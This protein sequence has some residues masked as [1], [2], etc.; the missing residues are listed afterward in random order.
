MFDISFVYWNPLF[1]TRRSLWP[2]FARLKLVNN[3]S[4]CFM[5]DF[6]EML[7]STEKFG[8]TNVE[9]IRMNLFREFLDS[10]GLM[11]LSLQGCKFTWISN[12]SN[13]FVTR[14]KIDNV[15][16]NWFGRN[17][18]PHA[19]FLALPII[20]SDHSPIILNPNPPIASGKS[21]KYESFGEE[22]DDYRRE[23]STGWI[24]SSHTDS[25]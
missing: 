24:S 5:G 6:N 18:L 2:I 13:V 3:G 25:W 1:S 11:D 15:L 4:W 17:R 7:Y 20:N 14:Q 19:L 23:L 12:P 10:P 22:H 9:P 21:I 8:L 16:A